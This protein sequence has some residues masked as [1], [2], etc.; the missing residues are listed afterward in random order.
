MK[1]AINQSV[2][3]VAALLLLVAVCW[4]GRGTCWAH[5]PV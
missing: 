4:V 1:P 2:L 3:A 5:W